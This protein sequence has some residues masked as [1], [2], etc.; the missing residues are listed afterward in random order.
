M[1][2]LKDVAKAAGVSES[3][4]SKALNGRRDVGPSAL[5]KVAKAAEELGY[6]RRSR[7]EVVDSVAIVFESLQNPYTLQIISG[8][9][10]AAARAGVAL[11][12]YGARESAEQLFSAAWLAQARDRGHRAII[13][14]TMLLSSEA[15][16]LLRAEGL[17]LLV[18][19]P[20][21][22]LPD[23]VVTI[24]STNWEGGKAATEHLLG[25]GHR[26]IGVI[27][28]DSN[29]VPA[30]DRVEGYR[31]ALTA[32]GLSVDPALVLSA[33]FQFEDGERAMEQLLALPAPPT[34]VFACNDAAALGALRAAHR[35]GRSVPEELSIVGFDD[36]VLSS[37]S[38]PRLTTVRQPLE[39]M[40]QVAVERGLALS[41]DPGRFAH[42]F[43][44]QT[45]LVVRE[46]SAPPRPLD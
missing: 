34:A 28:G 5:R 22:D 15:L 17:P 32:I 18:I 24:G 46:T 42:P 27:A 12:V 4:A 14:S 30:R 7:G 25:L 6:E 19:D 37:W 29:S 20:V 13:V 33:G 1:V 2:T 38:T 39:S 43:Q 44:L 3:T 21:Q 31:S 11:A 23:E 40:G 36:T 9:S 35:H 41:A 10:R 45:Q 16:V 26:R 8:A